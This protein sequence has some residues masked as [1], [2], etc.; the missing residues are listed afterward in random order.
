MPTK[1]LNHRTKT[2]SIHVLPVSSREL[3]TN[4]DKVRGQVAVYAPS[5]RHVTNLAYLVKWKSRD[6]D[7]E[8]M[9]QSCQLQFIPIAD[10]VSDP[11]TLVRRAAG[12][13]VD[14]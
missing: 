14:N 13:D 9:D 12:A 8:P 5:G 6:V 3:L 2:L 7:I 11:I 10:L 4:C 1:C